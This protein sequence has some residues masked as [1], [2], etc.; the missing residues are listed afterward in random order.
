MLL[1]KRCFASLIVLALVLMLNVSTAMAKTPKVHIT[2]PPKER[3]QTVGKSF[4]I[5]V[6]ASGFDK[7]WVEVASPDVI[8]VLPMEQKKYNYL[9]F[10]PTDSGEHTIT[11]VVMMNGKAQ[12]WTS[13]I[14]L[15]V[16]PIDASERAEWMVAKA[17]SCVGSTDVA[18]FVEHTSLS[19]DDEWCAAFIGWCSKQI[20]IP[21]KAGIQAICAGIDIYS[22]QDTPIPCKACNANHLARFLG[23]VLAS[24]ESPKPGD[25]VFFIWGSKV[26]SQ[27]DA[28]PGY[29][30]NWHG[31]ANHVGLVTEVDG[32]SF[33]FV[34]GNVYIKHNLYG[35]ALN[36]STDEKYGKTFGDWVVAFAHPDYDYQESD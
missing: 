35:V 22:G 11:A 2:G 6:F 15:T 28:H 4:L 27:E 30:S 19:E 10:T 29:Q 13:A 26:K 20:H 5:G 3:A 17:L 1:K 18:Q 12:R 34:H 8:H 24:V 32:S 23:T 9:A 16:Y 36:K 7:G 21:Y 14:Q 25:L 33:S 31:N